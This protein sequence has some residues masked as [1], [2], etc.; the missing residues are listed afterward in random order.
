MLKLLGCLLVVGACGALGL[1]AR[2]Q[3]RARVSAINAMLDAL[4]TL[5]VEIE[6][7][8]SPLP[9]VFARLAQSANGRQKRLFGEICRRMEQ[10]PGMSLGYHWS[11]TVRD[12]A[13]ELG[14]APPECTALRDA[15][16]FL[17]RYDSAQQIECLRQTAR[18][19]EECRRE[20]C[21]ALH[22]KGNVYRTCGLAAGLLAVLVLV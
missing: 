4:T 14:L 19:L 3:L 13:D 15:A 11:S 16:A 5:C 22:Q 12:L 9:A 10:A 6:G 20:A 18:K 1:S 2:Q 8:L 17:G 7:S 21:E